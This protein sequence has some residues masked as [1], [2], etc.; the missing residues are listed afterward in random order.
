MKQSEIAKHIS[1]RTHLRLSAVNTVLRS[2]CQI[3]SEALEADDTVRINIGVF[4]PRMRPPKPAYDFNEK[5]KITLPPATYV[6][7]RPASKIQQMLKEK[8]A[9]LAFNFAKDNDAT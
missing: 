2:L 7:Y 8:D 4:E 3:M 1:K 9:Q 6:V 5:K